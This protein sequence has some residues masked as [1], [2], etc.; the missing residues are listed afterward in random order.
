MDN[1]THISGKSLDGFVKMAVAGNENVDMD[2]VKILC[3]HID[4]LRATI[5]IQDDTIAALKIH[6]D[7]L[8]DQNISLRTRLSEKV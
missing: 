5:G 6:K 8:S 4:D 7:F 3:Q 1:K 2:T